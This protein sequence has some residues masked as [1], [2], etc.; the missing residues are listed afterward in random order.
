M[1]GE[2]PHRRWL[3]HERRVVLMAL[4][5][6]LPGVVTA[7]VLLWHG[8]FAPKVQ[9]TL[10]ALIVTVWLGFS[11]ALQH[12]VVY[13]LQTLSNL[14]A[15][16]REGDASFRAR[17]ARR[18]DVLGSVM[19]EAN[20]LAETLHEQRLDA[21]EATALLRRVMAEIDVAVFAFDASE[22]LRLVNRA[23]ER[24]LARP[25]ERLLGSTADDL[26]LAAPLR[27]EARRVLDV[28]FPG[29]TGRWEVRRSSFRLGGLPHQLL[30][31]TDVSRPLRDEERQA[32]QR[33]MRVLGHEINNSLAPIK[34]I[35]G[36]LETL[37]TREPLAGDWRED[38]RR[39]LG[40]IAARAE[41]LSRFTA[42]YARLAKLPRPRLHPLA[43]G[44]VVRRVVGLDRRLPISLQPGPE[45]TVRADG[46]QI[47]QLLINLVKNA[48]DAALET[49]G[50]VRVGW[51]RR[52]KQLEIWVEDDGPGLAQTANL[53]VPFF[54]TKPGGSGIGLVL[55]R[56][57]A[58]AHGGSLTLEN[59]ADARGCV[60]KFRLPILD[61][62]SP[63]TTV[64]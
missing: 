17:G 60:A 39:G 12:R 45:I 18:D 22:R 54:T 6:G 56:Q 34:S 26:G 3:T 16:L 49:N 36:S 44:P 42:S 40:V 35:A 51:Q 1:R 2:A 46:D 9:W 57:I 64:A 53:F 37:V 27:E 30:V 61:Q 5:A 52:A 38:A 50:A 58:E 10:S 59:R 4:A 25:A 19:L 63:P 32:W 33:L 41:A 8:A 14:L 55:G 28:A 7:M 24:L 43:V 23:G 21:L 15:G 48:V 11:L 13:P 20:T 62:P 31:L 29:G 47:E